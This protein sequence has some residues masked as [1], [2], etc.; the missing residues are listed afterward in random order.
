[1]YTPDSYGSMHHCV[2]NFLTHDAINTAARVCLGD[3]VLKTDGT[4]SCPDESPILLRLAT[5]AHSRYTTS[6]CKRGL[7]N[8]YRQLNFRI[9]LPF[10]HFARWI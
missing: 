6:G 4:A 3:A 7:D 10:E 1:M 8:A 5:A 9:V 2:C